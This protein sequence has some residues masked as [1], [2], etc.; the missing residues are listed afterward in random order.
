[1]LMN[2]LQTSAAPVSLQN[3]KFPAFHLDKL[4]V[5]KF[6]LTQAGL[7]SFQEALVRRPQLLFIYFSTPF[8]IIPDPLTNPPIAL[9]ICHSLGT[10]FWMGQHRPSTKLGVHQVALFL[11]PSRSQAQSPFV[12]LELELLSNLL[13]CQIQLRSV[14]SL[15]R[16]KHEIRDT[17][18]RSWGWPIRSKANFCH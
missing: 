6:S 8:L 2:V 10:Q 15:G 4:F 12:S 1:V 16:S 7:I 11:G 3:L 14:G 13:C 18:P 9:R 5:Q 17:F